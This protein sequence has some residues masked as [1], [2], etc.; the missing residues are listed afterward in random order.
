MSRT[1][2]ITTIVLLISTSAMAQLP[3]NLNGWY[4]SPRLVGT[5]PSVLLISTTPLTHPPADFIGAYQSQQFV[6]GITNSVQLDH[7]DYGQN[8]VSVTINNNQDANNALHQIA[9]QGQDAFLMQVGNTSADG[10]I[11]AIT[12]ELGTVGSQGQTVEPH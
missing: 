1:T 8:I 2:A 4:Q 9:N 6:G 5:V 12:Q 3:A 11:V 10:G 7:G